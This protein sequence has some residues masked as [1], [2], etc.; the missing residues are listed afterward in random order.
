[1]GKRRLLKDVALWAAALAIAAAA[2]GGVV[3]AAYI[4]LLVTARHTGGPV[5]FSGG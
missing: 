1:M 5:L 4:M 3:I 2:T